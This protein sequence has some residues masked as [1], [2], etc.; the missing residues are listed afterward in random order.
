MAPT[1]INRDLEPDQLKRI[2]NEFIPAVC[3]NRAHDYVRGG[4]E[5]KKNNVKS[6]TEKGFPNDVF[7]CSRF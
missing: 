4:K 5:I 7:F 6:F 1:Y 3:L 2:T